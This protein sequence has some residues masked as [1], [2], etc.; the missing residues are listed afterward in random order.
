MGANALIAH[1]VLRMLAA[2]G[3][4][5]RC[6]LP[7]CCALPTALLPTYSNSPGLAIMLAPSCAECGRQALRRAVV[8]MHA[9]STGAEQPTSAPPALAVAQAAQWVATRCGGQH[10]REWV[11]KSC[12]SSSTQTP[13]PLPRPGVGPPNHSCPHPHARHHYAGI[14]P[15][16]RS[17]AA[18]PQRA[19][20]RAGCAPRWRTWWPSCSRSAW[21]RAR[22]AAP[23]GPP[24]RR[25]ALWRPSRCAVGWGVLRATGGEDGAACSEACCLLAHNQSCAD[26]GLTPFCCRLPP[27]ANPQASLQAAAGAGLEVGGNEHRWQGPGAAAELAADLVHDPVTRMFW[28]NVRARVGGRLD[29]QHRRGQRGRGQASSVSTHVPG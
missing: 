19:V 10:W 1:R 23:R 17:W 29:L 6:A 12:G 8:G 11:S 15:P 22:T 25:S 26:A 16:L 14:G 20:Q 9:T 13:L 21:G 18:T 7:L 3:A 4:W 27:T 24:P 5:A 28:R 2:A